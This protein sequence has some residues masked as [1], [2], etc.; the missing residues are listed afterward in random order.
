MAEN[1]N[2]KALVHYNYVLLI[3]GNE[4]RRRLPTLPT[5]PRGSPRA[6]PRNSFSGTSPHPPKPP[7]GDHGWIQ[8]G[9]GLEDTNLVV[10][11]WAAESL[12]MVETSESLALPKPYAI[13]KL[14]MYG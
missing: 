12:K 13:V 2:L 4:S 14:C 6:S 8:L 1:F 11:L 10:N 3:K 7:S 5:S 9:L